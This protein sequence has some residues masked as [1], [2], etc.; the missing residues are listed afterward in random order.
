MRINNQVK[1]VLTVLLIVVFAGLIRIPSLTQ[2]LGPDQGVVA[3]IGKG[4]LNGELPYRD[5]WEMGSPAIF[6]TYALIFK[7]FGVSMAAIPIAD[8]LV[9]M[10]TTLL[11][12]LLARS[13]WD[14]KT[15]Y[16]S[17][18]F[19]AFF[20]NGVCLGM[21]SGGDIAFGTFW[22][23]AQRESFLL[24]LAVASIYLIVSSEIKQITSF[25]LFLSGL[26]AGLAFVYKFPAVLIFF[27]ILIYLNGTVLWG[28]TGERPTILVKKNVT[29]L[30]G[31]ALAI[32]PFGIFFVFKGA[33]S[34]MTDAVFKYVFSVYGNLEHN[35][36]GIAKMGLTRTLFI[37]KEQFILWI[38]FIT[39]S[40]YILVNSRTKEN[41]LVVLWALA[42]LFFVI[43][44]REFFGYHYL[45]VIPPFSILTGYGIIKALGP[46]FSVRQMFSSELGK[47]FVVLT[48]M[49][50][51]L[52]FATLN[53]M[54][55]TKFYYYVTGKINKIQ[56]YDFFRAYPKHDYSFPADYSVAQYVAER[57][58]VDDK[59][60]II[61]GIESV[62]HFLSERR[63]PS[64]FIFSW[65]IL[66][67]HMHSRVKQ[68]ELYREE[69][70]KA[71]RA[72]TPE[73]IIT[74]RPIEHFHE[75]AD[76][77]RFVKANYILEKTFQDDR[78]VYTY[79]EHPNKA[80]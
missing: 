12:F 42:S 31:F 30:L 57:T 58:D 62:I 15:G 67:P 17:A 51:L 16:V 74:I 2:P 29:L 1:E 9:S 48:L 79:K 60:Y 77:F 45:M 11:I 64:R 40:V 20:S 34:D 56:Y 32:L 4:I 8:M 26:L 49:A 73:Y 23:I 69:L 52:F 37:G 61:G 71:L 10:L 55:Y 65:I 41:L 14:N 3:V 80:I 33:M 22:Y 5:Y 25:R 66:S 24:P 50:N 6:F 28:K 35:Y 72:E 46:T 21:H 38:F 76:I 39:S 68:A 70:L 75:F 27:C 78:F 43:S 7:V 63:S 18:L 19:F 44:H 59:I 53:Y 36:L 13:I 47:A 54:H